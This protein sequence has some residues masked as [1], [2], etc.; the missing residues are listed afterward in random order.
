MPFYKETIKQNKAGKIYRTFA[1]KIN[2]LSQ[3]FQVKLNSF[4]FVH[5]IY[6]K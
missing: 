6:K 3:A 1:N 4:H 2:T 5:R